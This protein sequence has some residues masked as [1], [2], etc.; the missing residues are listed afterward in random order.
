MKKVFLITLLVFALLLIACDTNDFDADKKDGEMLSD[1][2]L[3]EEKNG[4]IYFNYSENAPQMILKGESET[5]IKS[6]KFFDALSRAVDDKAIVK[7]V[8]NCEALYVIKVGSYTFGLHTHGISIYNGDSIKSK[9]LIGSAQLKRDDMN[10]LFNLLKATIDG[11]QLSDVKLLE[12][13]G[14]IKNVFVTS[15]PESASRAYS[16]SGD[17]AK[18]VVNYLNSLNLITNFEENPNEYGGMTWVI[19]IEY[20]NGDTA[21]VYHFGNIFIRANDG[22]WY[23]MIHEEAS[24]LDKLLNELNN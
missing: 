24:R 3:L 15:L 18:S 10:H 2:K 8:C 23:K 5:E 14:D 20:N 22:N 17:D 4:A 19:S 7:D 21:T 1:F 12:E 9:D 13:K 11:E 6:E 16:F